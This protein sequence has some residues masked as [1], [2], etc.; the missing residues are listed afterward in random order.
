MKKQNQLNLKVRGGDTKLTVKTKDLCLRGNIFKIR[1]NSAIGFSKN[2]HL[3]P[4]V[5]CA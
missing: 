4:T 3:I 5:Q 1:L 2:G